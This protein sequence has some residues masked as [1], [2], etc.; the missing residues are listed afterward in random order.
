MHI[1]LTQDYYGFVRQSLPSDRQAAPEQAPPRSP[2][3]R[4]QTVLP[5]ERL[6]EGELLKNRQKNSSGLDDFLQRG[7]FANDAAAAD[8]TPQTAQRAIDTYLGYANAP[9]GNAGVA[10][11]IDYYA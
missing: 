8:V 3:P 2:P 4:P 9:A 11:S 1:K 5:A 10:L 6:V 7:R